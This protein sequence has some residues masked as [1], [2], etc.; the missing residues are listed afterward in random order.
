MCTF[1]YGHVVIGHI[2]YVVGGGQVG[3]P[4]GGE[5]TELSSMNR[6]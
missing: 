6:L 4:V 1:N 5:E 3:W 2:G